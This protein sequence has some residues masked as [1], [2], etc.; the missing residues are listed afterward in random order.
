MAR[1][2]QTVQRH[3]GVDEVDCS[4]LDPKKSR[5]ED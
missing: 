3:F 2:P 5:V 1:T 4:P